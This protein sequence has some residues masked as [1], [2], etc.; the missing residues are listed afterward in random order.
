MYDS[1]LAELPMDHGPILKL[2]QMKEVERADLGKDAADY[3]ALMQEHERKAV[4]IRALLAEISARQ[5]RVSEEISLLRQAIG[6][7]VSESPADISTIDNQFMIE[8]SSMPGTPP[9]KIDVRELDLSDGEPKVRQHT[10]EV[11]RRVVILLATHGPMSSSDI[12]EAMRSSGF[13]VSI[14]NEVANLSAILSRTTFFSSQA[15]RWHLDATKLLSAPRLT[16]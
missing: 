16:K 3:A 14:E 9:R 7:E 2:I 1:S 5:M 13:T 6:S 4:E 10:I 11:R 8:I 15:R 12:I